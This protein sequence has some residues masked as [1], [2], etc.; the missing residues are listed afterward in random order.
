MKPRPQR[1]PQSDDLEPIDATARDWLLRL[2][3]RQASQEEL[4]AFAAW[5]D[6]DPC[7]LA[8]YEEMRSLWTEI[9]DLQPAFAPPPRRHDIWRRRM[10]IGTGLLA[11]SLALA[12]AIEPN[13]PARLMADAHTV[14]GRQEMLTLPDGSVAY[15]NTDTAIAVDYTDA[16]RRVRLLYGEALFEVRKDSHRPFDV[17]ALDGRTTAVGTAFAVRDDAETATVTVTEG[18]V[19][20]A[21]PSRRDAERM[22]NVA[23]VEAGQQTNYRRGESPGPVRTADAAATAWRDGLLVIRDQPFVEAIAQIERYRPG[24]ILLMGDEARLQTVTAH[25]S[26]RD[27]DSGLEALAATHGLSVL[28]L[29]NYLVVLR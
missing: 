5:R 15:L 22:E 26:L 25:I 28:R 9:D 19:T 16:R 6:A 27:I 10:V 24:K 17:L 8:A 29:T 12:L 13:L 18:I 21:S 3:S 4:R 2:T 7:H 1:Q 23:V 20:V 11:A 14:V